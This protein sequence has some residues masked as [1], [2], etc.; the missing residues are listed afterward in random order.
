[1][2]A[3][4]Q[5]AGAMGEGPECWFYALDNKSRDR[6]GRTTDPVF[7]ELRAA[8]TQIARKDTR[9]VRDLQGNPTRYMEFSM[10]IKALELLDSLKHMHGQV[11]LM[12]DVHREAELFALDGPYQV[13]T[14]MKAFNNLGMVMW[15]ANVSGCD[16]L[17][18]LEPQWLVNS[19]ACLIRDAELH[20]SIIEEMETD[21]VL[22]KSQAI[23]WNKEDVNAGLFPTKLLDYIWSHKKKYGKLGATGHILDGLK[24]V[25]RNFHLVYPIKRGLHDFYVVPVRVPYA[26]IPQD[27]VSVAVSFDWIVLALRA[28]GAHPEV[29]DFKLDFSK[30]KFLP[31]HIFHVLLCAVARDVSPNTDELRI[32]FYKREVT[33]AFGSHYVCARLNKREHCIHVYTINHGETDANTRKTAKF[34]LEIF[35]KYVRKLSEPL[36]LQ[37]KVLL[38]CDQTNPPKYVRDNNKEYWTEP[39]NRTVWMDASTHVRVMHRFSKDITT[40][41]H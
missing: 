19:M 39:E 30:Q 4:I 14:L 25:L 37:Y 21:E 10:P 35:K 1:M 34:W 33:I 23:L 2:I 27:P 5:I 22:N 38:R 24:S 15:F 32:D 17:V 26:P 8:L 29:W 16:H 11:C 40:S 36:G 12:E 9:T 31:P 6:K 3:L 13:E 28:R 18:I 41:S 7:I 20:G